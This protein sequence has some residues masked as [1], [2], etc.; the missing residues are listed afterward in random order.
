MTN[1]FHLGKK[2]TT[3]LHYA[4]IFVVIMLFVYG[5][6]SIFTYLINTEFFD[7]FD[8]TGIND[9]ATEY[10]E[11]K[12]LSANRMA[13]TLIVLLMVILILFVGVTCY[14][15]ARPAIFFLITFIM[16]PFL[17]FVAYIFN[18]IFD[19]ITGN[20]V[21]DAVIATFPKTVLICS[22]LHWIAFVMIIVGAITAYTRRDTGQM[23]IGRGGFE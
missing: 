11:D 9:S 1:L 10:V 16:A 21:F 4:V 18:Y 6:I 8:A 22:N 12:F 2:G 20:A 14:R 7:A 23:E 19:E 17:C 5:L 15:N 3:T 13:D